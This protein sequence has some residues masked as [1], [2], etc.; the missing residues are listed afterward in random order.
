[1]NAGDKLH[2][3][4]P[5]PAIRHL[6]T[7]HLCLVLL[8]LGGALFVAARWLMRPPAG[9]LGILVTAAWVAVAA[10]TTYLVSVAAAE[11]QHGLTLRRRAHDREG[12]LPRV[13]PQLVLLCAM[14]WAAWLGPVSR[15]FLVGL[16]ALLAAAGTIACLS[17]LLAACD[18]TVR[19]WAGSAAGLDASAPSSSR[20]QKWQIATGLLALAFAAALVVLESLPLPGPPVSPKSEQRSTLR[21]RSVIRLSGRSVSVFR[22]GSAVLVADAKVRGD[23]RPHRRAK[24]S[25]RQLQRAAD[26]PPHAPARRRWRR[27]RFFGPIGAVRGGS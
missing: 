10:G 5:T 17:L 14:A 1:M 9:D 8:S 27:G 15:S 25:S 4:W 20:D 13:V 18:T 6:G 3:S 16:D 21:D 26:S 2:P 22:D 12:I 7:G 19:G 23:T 24:E 11:L